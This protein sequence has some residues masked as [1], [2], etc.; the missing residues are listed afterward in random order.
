MFLAGDFN[1]KAND[2]SLKP[3]RKDGRFKALTS[4]ANRAPDSGTV[5]YLVD[6]F[7][8]LI[9]H[10]MYRRRDSRKTRVNKSTVIFDP[11][12]AGTE[13]AEFVNDYSDHAPVVAS[14]YIDRP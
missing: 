8:S 4:T 14:F 12:T 3:L 5:T 9:D 1:A 11:D 2:S 13:F 7:R 6:P 10:V